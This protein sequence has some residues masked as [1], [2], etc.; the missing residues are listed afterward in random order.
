[1]AVIF[2][3]WS[4]IF[5]CALY[6][7]RQVGGLSNPSHPDVLVFLWQA[8]RCLPCESTEHQAKFLGVLYKNE[9]PPREST[10]HSVAEMTKTMQIMI[11]F[12]YA[13]NEAPTCFAKSSPI[14]S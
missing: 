11:I 6:K 13:V 3:D 14:S 2:A 12:K 8:L 1:M 4:I 10:C 5:D 7:L 9:D